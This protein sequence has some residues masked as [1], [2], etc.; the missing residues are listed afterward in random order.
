MPKLLAFAGSSREES[1]NKKLVRIAAAGARQ[2]GAEVTLVDLGDFPMPIFN[3]DLESA[4]GMPEKAGE[5]K[6]LMV[7]HDGFLVASPEYNSSYS[8]LLKNAIDWASRSEA[9]SEAPLS[10]FRGKT[11]ALM[12]ASPGGYGGM[13]G[14]VVLRMLLA[15]LGVILLPDQV[16]VAHAFRAFDE[17]GALTDEKQQAAVIK[18]GSSLAEFCA[19]RNRTG[20]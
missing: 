7:A 17:N 6:E 20:A 18:L 3:Q 11:A 15:N 4:R 5:F 12:S 13:R 19:S 8:P 1:F 9:E 2:A 10:A 14:L 16:T